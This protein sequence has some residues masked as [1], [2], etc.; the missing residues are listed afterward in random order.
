MIIAG[1]SDKVGRRPAYI[2]CFVIYI[3]AN[4]ALALNNTYGGL[5]GLR[6]LQSAGSSGT[7]ALANGVVADVVTSAER[8]QYIAFASLATVLGPSL[9]PIIG[10]LI[11]QNLDWHWIFWF[12][13]IFSVVTTVPFMLFMPETGRKIVDDGSIPPPPLNNNLSDV[14]RHSRRR[15][16]GIEPDPAVVAKLRENY[17]LEF[18]NPLPSLK[19]ILDLE[20]G[21][22]L[23]V[24]GMGLACFYAISTGASASFRDIYGFSDIKIALMFIPIGAGGIISAFTTG[25]LV[26]WNFRRHCK[27]QGVEI[28]KGVKMDLTDFPIEKARLEVSL[29]LYLGGIAAVIGYGWM[30]EAGKISLAGPVIMFLILGYCLIATNQGLNVLMV[31]I[32]PGKPAAATASNNL[33]RCLLGA[34]A[35]AAIEPM[36]QAMGYGWAYTTLGLLS[37]STAPLLVVLMRNGISWRKKRAERKVRREERRRERA[38]RN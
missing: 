24:T 29:P 14:W 13:L 20:S 28:K 26:D 6:C 33:V 23:V 2:L 21:L 15:K 36:R 18:P 17:R 32:W 27:K 1:F 11:A 37:V 16:E 35:T 31:D 12:L 7:V 10:G 38:S 22:V 4:L 8:G 9:S 34:A 30:L 25:R 19:I 3:I 5:L